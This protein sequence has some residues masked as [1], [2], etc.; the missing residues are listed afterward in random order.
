ML[1][2]N[3]EALRAFC[4]QDPKLQAQMIQAV[5]KATAEKLLKWDKVI[6]NPVVS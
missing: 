3:A 2:G 5:L 1:D 4:Q 6:D